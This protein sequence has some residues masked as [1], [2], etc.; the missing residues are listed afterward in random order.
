M[1]EMIE[2]DILNNTSGI[3]C[4]QVNC[5]AMGK[6]LA[7]DI[8]EKYP[9]VYEEYIKTITGLNDISRHSL[10]GGVLYVPI[11]S[12]LT[13]ANLFGQY[14][15]KQYNDIQSVYTDY[16]ALSSCLSNIKDYVLITG[17]DVHIPYEIGC[18]LGGGSWDNVYS[19]IEKI[20][21]RTDINCFIN[22]MGVN[23][24]R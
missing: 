5:F 23:N 3:I 16:T 9:V 2:R 19:I 21:T 20:F 8:K 4:H 10:L 13:I 17:M 15:Y 18:G 14:K 24:D 12:S 6:G 11:N 22:R 1:I 7:K